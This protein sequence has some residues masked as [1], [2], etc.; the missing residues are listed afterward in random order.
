MNGPRTAFVRARLLDPASGLDAPGSLLVEGEKILDVGPELFADGTPS[1]VVEVNCA[2]L[3]LAPGLIDMHVFTGEPGAEHD[4][5]LASAGRAAAAGGVTT[6]AVM[7]NT[8]PVIDEVALVEFIARRGRESALVNVLPV[9]AATKGLGGKE[10]SEIGL[11]RE[12]GAVAFSDG[13]RAIAN[14]RI[15][16][17]ILSY[18]TVFD[19]LTV[20]ICE[21][22]SLAKDGAMNEGE[23]ATRL[24]LAGIPTM[25][26]TI[27]VERDLRLVEATRGRWHAAHLSTAE[28]LD[29]IRRAKA[30]GLKVSAGVAP[31]SFALNETAIGEYRTFCK[32]Q[33][34]LRTE[35]DRLATVAALRDGTIDVISS[36]HRPRDPESKRLPLGQAEFGAVG[37][38]TMLPLAL[39]LYHNGSL[40]L[41]DVLA[42][43]TANPARLMG[44]PGGRLSAGA[45]AD[46][47]LFDLDTPWMIDG[48]KLRSKAKNTPFDGR[49]VQG[50]VRR[51]VV[52]GRTVFER[53]REN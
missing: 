27:L 2:G 21:E 38:E 26:E 5:T 41:L 34:P 32:V 25:A 6:M 45:P 1:G 3:C 9:A 37:V 16:R 39:E 19:A 7:P 10:M 30:R 29:A 24:G 51:T 20:Q 4:E 47:V 22:P 23:T 12:A 48:T 8:D 43:M 15:M 52:N 42:K 31:Y 40:K 33:P 11:L 28:A 46:L 35:D 13:D 50:H 44:L 14:A 36:G 17:R 53:K 18:A 49:P